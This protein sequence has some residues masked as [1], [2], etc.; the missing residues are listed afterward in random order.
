VAVYLNRAAY[1]SILAKATSRENAVGQ[2]RNL[3]NA[4]YKVR[5]ANFA[6][7]AR[8]MN[9]KFQIKTLTFAN[10]KARLNQFTKS[11]AA[12]RK[13]QYSLVWKGIPMAQRKVLMHWRDKGEWLANNAF[14]NGK[15]PIK[16]NVPSPAPISPRT[17]RATKVKTN[18]EA[19]WKS[20]QPENRKIVR[21]YLA[22]HKS[23]SPVKPKSPSPVKSA[24]SAAKRSVNALNSAKKRK[25]YRR[26]R[27]VNM[28]QNNW[29]ELSKYIERKNMEA[30]WAKKSVAK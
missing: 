28:S 15:T 16:K 17:A 29:S 19:Y 23:P 10:A 26:K 18:F 6:N 3:Q 30:R 9:V 8:R 5:N 14:S 25:E 12:V 13:H 7:F 2:M 27:A 24:L 4:G 21:N 1:N 11:T 22:A 20:L